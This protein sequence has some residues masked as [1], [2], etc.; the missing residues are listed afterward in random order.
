MTRHRLL[1]PS[2]GFLF[3]TAS[4]LMLFSLLAWGYSTP[5]LERG[6]MTL[7]KMQRDNFAGFSETDVKTLAALLD[8]YPQFHKALIGRAEVG[9]V[10]LTQEGWSSARDSHLVIRPS[11][12]GAP[13]IEVECRA[14]KH[15]Y[16]VVVR[17]EAP[18]F[19]K[20][21]SFA[22]DATQPLEW[23]RLSNARPIMAHVHVAPQQAPVSSSMRPEIRFKAV[24]ADSQGVVP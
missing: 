20:V 7:Q 18:G 6:W 9:L 3:L 2:I 12:P 22:A 11:P 17:V 24:A 1:W 23:P 8:K 10:E 21:I 15:A 19:N 16:P 13:N 4:Y 14:P 5:D